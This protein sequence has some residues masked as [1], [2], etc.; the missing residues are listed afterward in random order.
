MN[1]SKATNSTDRSKHLTPRVDLLA[2][3]L[4]IYT[5]DDLTQL[6]Q[7]SRQAAEQTRPAN[8]DGY[9][10]LE[11]DVQ[12]RFKSGQ[13]GFVGLNLWWKHGRKRN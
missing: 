8:N 1:Q 2:A 4:E 5:E 12:V 3:L 9:A 10:G 13:L 11:A 7:F 6:V